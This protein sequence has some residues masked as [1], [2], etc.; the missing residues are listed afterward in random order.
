MKKNILIIGNSAKEYSLAKILSESFNVFVAPGNDAIS[1]FAT[2]VDIREN[3]VAELV[4]FALEND[5]SFTIC[6]SEIAIE[7]DIARL[8]EINNLR[9]FAPSK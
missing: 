9:I 8:F 7:A 1:E 3:S 2:V 5:I 6:S 4:D